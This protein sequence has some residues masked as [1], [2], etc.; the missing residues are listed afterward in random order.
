MTLG[1]F[2]EGFRNANNT[3]EDSGVPPEIRT[4]CPR[5]AVL[6]RYSYNAIFGAKG[7][8]RPT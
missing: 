1:I 5:N 2:M 8:I 4:Q 7:L 6:G 3:K